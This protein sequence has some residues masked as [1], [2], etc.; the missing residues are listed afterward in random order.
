MT[1][2]QLP[3]QAQEKNIE[4]PPGVDVIAA[5]KH[6]I[7]HDNHG[8]PFILVGHSQGSAVLRYFLSAYMKTHPGIYKR[9]VA[10]YIVGQSITPG[11]LANNPHLKYTKGPND[12]GVIVSWNTESTSTA[13]PNPVLLPNGI[14]VNPI[15]WTRG[16]KTATAA[17]NLGSIELDPST[18]GTPVL[19]RDGSVKRFR[20]VADATVS[21]SKGVVICS[22]VPA[23]QPP[24]FKPGGMPEG[25]LHVYDY[26]LYFFNVRANAHNRVQHFFASHK[27]F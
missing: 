3:A 27:G 21:K 4:G 9:M 5:F 1:Q 2:L 6:Y 14:A 15:T 18:G 23:S 22:T 8:R 7:K 11:Y 10:A 19:K 26:P 17:Q 24:Y 16:E 25:V 13:G 12:T 20:N